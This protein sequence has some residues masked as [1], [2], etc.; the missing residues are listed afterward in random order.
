VLEALPSVAVPVGHL[1]E[2]LPALAP[3][4][5]SISSSPLEH[6]G[7]IHIT[8][9]VTRFTTRTGRLHHGVCSTHFLR[10]LPGTAQG[11]QPPNDATHDTTTTHI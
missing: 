9:V 1:L 8:C 4:Y 7:R 11:N 6:P 3:R 10:L 5:Y 2:L